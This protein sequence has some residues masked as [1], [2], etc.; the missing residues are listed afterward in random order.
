MFNQYSILIV[1]D[2]SNMRRLIKNILKNNG[3]VNIYEAGDGKEALE[4][5]D[6]HAIDVIISDWNMTKMDG[7]TLLKSIRSNE[8]SK[9]IPF[10]MVTAE[11]TKENIIEAIT[12]GVSSY[13]VKPVTAEIMI[14]KLK[15]ILNI[16]E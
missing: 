11:V 12:Q 10:L 15:E 7:L 3:F 2:L 8:N 16:K 1:E 14:S 9:T 4:L 13:M 5:I 6:T